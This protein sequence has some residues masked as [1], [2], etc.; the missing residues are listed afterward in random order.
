MNQCLEGRVAVVSGAGSG[1][2][3]GVARVLARHGCMVV[4][5]TRTAAS[6]QLTVDEIIGSGGRAHLQVCNFET[7]VGCD[8]AIAAASTHFGRLDI[9]IHNAGIYPICSIAD[10]TEDVL[11][12][13]LAVNLKSAF[14]LTQAALPLLKSVPSPRIIFTS[15]VTGPRV[16]LPGLS[17]YAA[18]KSG[19][20]GFIRSAAMELAK[21]RITVNGIEPGLI[22]TDAIDAIADK[23]QAAAMVKQIPLKRFG[24]TE[25]I[26]YAMLYL[27]SDQAAFTTGQTIVVDGGA[28]LPENSSALE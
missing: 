22:G 25:E 28:L 6:G 5:A 8:L 3:R 9:L 23:E 14:W 12:T 27:A 20:N 1:I 16:A 11:E 19:L 15:S 17:H 26:G 4:V 10:M 7:R 21:Y 18:S 24:T 2:G 13:T